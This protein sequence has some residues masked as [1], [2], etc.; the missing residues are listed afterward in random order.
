M[1]VPPRKVIALIYLPV[2]SRARKSQCSKPL[3]I[4]RGSPKHGGLF[5]HRSFGFSLG[6]ILLLDS[7]PSSR[8]SN[9]LNGRARRAFAS[10]ICWKTH[11]LRGMFVYDRS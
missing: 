9:T 6:R 7:A 1:E 8:A 3:R 2:A 5:V 4:L 10:L 11:L